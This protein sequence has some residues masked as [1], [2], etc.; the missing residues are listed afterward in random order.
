MTEINVNL[1]LDKVHDL[2]MLSAQSSQSAQAPEER[3]GWLILFCGVALFINDLEPD[4]IKKHTFS[5]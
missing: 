3:P 5:Y 2:P 1:A 4:G